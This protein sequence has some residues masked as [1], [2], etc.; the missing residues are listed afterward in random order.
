MSYTTVQNH[1]R[2]AGARAYHRR[3][4]QAMTPIHMIKRVEF[5]CWVLREYG[6]AVTGDSVWGRLI[7]T[8]FSAMVKRNG[9]LNTKNH[10]VWSK[11]VNVLQIQRNYIYID[12]VFCNSDC[13]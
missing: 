1:L 4:I 2:I 10:V 9:I 8:D 5:R 11:V 12:F 6:R 13:L 7:N 3:K